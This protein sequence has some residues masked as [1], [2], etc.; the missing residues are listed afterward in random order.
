MHAIKPGNANI[1]LFCDGG[2][3]ESN[4]IA[5]ASWA[6][7]V[8]GGHWGEEESDVHPLAAECIFINNRISGFQTELTAAESTLEFICPLSV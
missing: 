7:F 4:A 5:S 3:W 2:S 6:A 1:L 8:L